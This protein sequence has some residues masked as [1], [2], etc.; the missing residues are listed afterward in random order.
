MALRDLAFA[1]MLIGGLPLAFMRPFVGA[2]VFVWLGMMNPH[3]YMWSFAGEISWSK[4]YAV[5][6]LLGA[7]ASKE[8]RWRES[9]RQYWIVLLFVAWASVTTA[10]ALEPTRAFNKFVD[11]VKIQAMCLVTLALL[12]TRARII[13]L[14]AVMSLSVAFF[15]TKGGVFTIVYGGEFKVWGPMK[16][17]IQDNNHLATGLV[18]TLPMLYWLSTVFKPWWIKLGL[19]GSMFLCAVS[20]FG[21]HSRGSF[22]AVAAMAVFFL[23]K[24]DRK[25][26]VIPLIVAGMATAVFV[27]PEKYWQRM[28]SIRT[29]QE[30]ESAMS[31]ITTWTTA[32]RVAADR[33]TGGGFEYYSPRSSARYSPK[34]EAVHSAHS[35]YFQALGEH[36]WIGLFLFLA[37][38][39]SVWWQSGKARKAL[40][41]GPEHDSTRLLL[42]MIQVSLIAYAVGGAF[43][44]IGY[45][46]FAYYLAIVVFAVR[47]MSASTQTSESV[48]EPVRRARVRPSV[49]FGNVRMH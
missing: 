48:P 47:R 49:A 6:V 35:I 36:G 30:D 28:E 34:P 1:L 18:M 29:Y 44:N 13:A 17:A 12:T 32:Y 10:F 9:V 37:F 43:L 22:L 11:V 23:L 45:W 4:L 21:S 46:D 20:V 24:S 38:W 3:Q 15:G 19:L 7:L 5:A 2:L 26:L 31:R 39:L 33:I 14:I 25:L 42:R 40:P 27:M 8:M 16:S 41:A